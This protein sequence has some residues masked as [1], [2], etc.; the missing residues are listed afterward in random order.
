MS[1]LG[2]Q[3]GTHLPQLL[4]AALLLALVFLLAETARLLAGRWWPGESA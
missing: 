1:L 4:V 2:Q 3:T